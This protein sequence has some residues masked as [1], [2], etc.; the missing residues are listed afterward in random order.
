[1]G[2]FGDQRAVWMKAVSVPRLA[3]FLANESAELSKCEDG[4]LW[5]WL[6]QFW[7]AA[8]FIEP[9]DFMTAE[10]ARLYD[11]RYRDPTPILVKYGVIEAL[12][13][14]ES[15]FSECAIWNRERVVQ[16]RNHRKSVVDGKRMGSGS[17][18]KKEEV[19]ALPPK[20]EAAAAAPPVQ[21]PKLIFEA[22]DGEE[23]IF[24]YD[25]KAKTFWADA[26]KIARVYGVARTTVAHHIRK[27]FAQGELVREST[28]RKFGQVA[29]NGKVYQIINYDLKMVIAAGL[30]IYSDEAVRFRRWVNGLVERQILVDAGI[31]APIESGSEAAKSAPRQGILAGAV[32]VEQV[33]KGEI[34]QPVLVFGEPVG[35]VMVDVAEAGI[36][37]RHLRTLVL[38]QVEGGADVVVSVEAGR[39]VDEWRRWVAASGLTNKQCFISVK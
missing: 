33:E 28:C 12:P 31:E 21:P 20:T 23:I 10:R 6:P 16:A 39:D 11:G 2:R 3:R 1:M 15:F 22:G 26:P 5:Q 25:A 27:I 17:R 18:P 35:R 14:G 9:N 24:D 8:L 34:F 32:G 7:E 13:C 29:S 38:A 30:G 4:D 19:A 37:A 36:H